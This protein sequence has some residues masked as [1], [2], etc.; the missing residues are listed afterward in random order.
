MTVSW[1]SWRLSP[2][3]DQLVLPVITSSPSTITIFRCMIACFSLWPIAM[4][5]P[6]LS[7]CHEARIAAS[8]FPAACVLSRLSWTKICSASSF[9]CR[10]RFSFSSS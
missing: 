4:L 2:P 5:L 10:I 6:I 3:V 9:S 7:L 8:A 1:L